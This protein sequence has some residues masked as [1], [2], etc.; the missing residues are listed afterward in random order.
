LLVSLDGEE[1]LTDY[2]RG[3]GTYRKVIA[4]LQQI[5]QTGFCGELIARMTIMEQTDIEKQVKHLLQNDEFRFSSIHWQLN[6]G[7]WGN[8]YRRRN[9]EEWTQTSYIPGVRAL[10]R[11]WVDE[12]ER[13]GWVLR[14]YPLLGIADS[15]LR[16]EKD[17]LMR[18]GAGWVNY[19]IQTDGFIIPCPTMWGMKRFYLGHIQ[20]A[21]PLCL[22]RLF[23]AEH[24]CSGCDILGVCGG[25]CLYTN[26]VKRWPDEAYGV[27][28]GT[29]RALIGGVVEE[30]PRIRRLI[31][32]GRLRLADFDYVKYNGAEIIP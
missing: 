20:D 24:P 31:A 13:H 6:A 9:F 17:V 27:V 23:V 16:G 22:K 5:K 2:Y 8:D 26:I 3:K 1:A 15:L 25:R 10:T 11:F 30:L 14:L 18:C 7:F 19:A 29:V 28:C 21:D 32:S 12:M 4:N